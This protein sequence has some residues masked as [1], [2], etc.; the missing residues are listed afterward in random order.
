M[1]LEMRTSQRDQLY[2]EFFVVQVEIAE[3]YKRFVDYVLGF[4]GGNGV[5]VD[6]Q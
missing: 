5:Y 1:L 4:D 3:K 2:Q 6:I